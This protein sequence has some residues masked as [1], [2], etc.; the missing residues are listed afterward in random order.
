MPGLH[1]GAGGRY[2]LVNP[3]HDGVLPG[4]IGTAVARFLAGAAPLRPPP[5]PPTT[6]FHRV[7]H[8]PINTVPPNDETFFDRSWRPGEIEPVT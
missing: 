4:G 7:S 1:R 2:L 5:E 6:V 3:G 8:L